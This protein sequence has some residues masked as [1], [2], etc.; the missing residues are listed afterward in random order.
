[1]KT[2][3]SGLVMLASCTFMGNST[4]SSQ[5]LMPLAQW[6]ERP[7][8]EQEPSYP[9]VRCSGYY[10]SIMN[11]TGAKFSKEEQDGFTWASFTLAFAAA[12]VR[13][14][15]EGSRL[16]VKDYAENVTK[17]VER[18]ADEYVKRMQRNSA[19]SGNAT[20]PLITGDGQM[21]KTIAEEVARNAR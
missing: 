20:D 3:L 17:D 19:R 8:E 14:I 12:Q 21:C 1:M 10:M 9:L 5:E 4:A 13:H 18:V 2:N 11:Y 6:F 15:K 7:A 16:P